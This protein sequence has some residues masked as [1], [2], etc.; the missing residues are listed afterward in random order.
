M[1]ENYFAED[2]PLLMRNAQAQWLSVK[3]NILIT[4]TEPVYSDKQIPPATPCRLTGLQ[5]WILPKGWAG[6]H[7]GPAGWKSRL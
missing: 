3:T 5:A 6:G 2:E 7:S 1:T 4:Y